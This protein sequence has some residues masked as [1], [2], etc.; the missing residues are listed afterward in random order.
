M[1]T[2]IGELRETSKALCAKGKGVL[3]A[4]EST[5]TIGKRLASIDCEN[6]EGARRALR[7][8]LF[9][10]N[11]IERH[12]S[13][14]IMVDETL[15]MKN[16][17]STSSFVEI[18]KQKGVLS[19]IKVDLGTEALPTSASELA[20]NGLDG[21]GA[22]CKEYY[23]LGAR[24]AKW[25]AVLKIDRSR[26]LPS[27]LALRENANALA[28]YATICQANGLVPIVEPEVLMEGTHDL[29]ACRAA[30]T[31]ALEE[32]FAALRL[33]GA[34]LDAMIL[35]P[36]MVT[37]G[38]ECVTEDASSLDSRVAFETVT[39]L[40]D[41]VPAS[42]PGI[43]F[44]SGG[45]SEEDATERLRLIVKVADDLRAPWT[46]SFSYGRALQSS[47]LKTWRG[48]DENIAPAQAALLARAAANSLAALGRP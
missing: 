21:L 27:A 18:L 2:Y 31:R 7:E 28:R 48:K 15:R 40:L 9:T 14:V 10:T 42:V 44:L 16:S 39:C 45:Q 19:G 5:T 37:P 13:G 12:V 4:D 47:C 22:R 30:T 32:V 36:N 41:V 43:L 17:A 35:K 26:G 1:E 34:R 29:A 20:T 38:S 8:L 25:R 24:F 11:G 46:L 23:A 33:H 6:T 3:A